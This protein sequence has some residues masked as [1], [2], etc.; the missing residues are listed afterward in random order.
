MVNV[1]GCLA[2]GVVVGLVGRGALGELWRL[3]LLTGFLGAFTTFSAFAADTWA[4]FEER[5]VVAALANWLGQSVLSA[6]LLVLG[7]SVA[8]VV[9]PR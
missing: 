4:L 9:A 8:Q 2:C 5:G 7:M 1:L 6:L 3:G